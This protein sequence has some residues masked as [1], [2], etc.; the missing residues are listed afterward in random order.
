MGLTTLYEMLASISSLT[1]SLVRVGFLPTFIT[2][3]F[4]S[5]SLTSSEQGLIRLNPG[6]RSLEN[7]PNVYTSP[8]ES[9]HVYRM[10]WGGGSRSSKS[11]RKGRKEHCRISKYRHSNLSIVRCMWEGLV[12][13][14]NI[15]VGRKWDSSWALL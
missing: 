5:T 9:V 10:R 7:L 1:L 13:F 4:K 12:C 11:I 14:V 2:F 3:N 6:L 8:T 15:G